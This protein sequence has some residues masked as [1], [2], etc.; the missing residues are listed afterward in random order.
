MLAGKE[1]PTTYFRKMKTKLPSLLKDI[2]IGMLI[3]DNHGQ[4]NSAH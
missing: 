2:R 3:D 4:L 1:L